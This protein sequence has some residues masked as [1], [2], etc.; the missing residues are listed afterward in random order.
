M[1]T[2]MM[3]CSF[4]DSW[5]IGFKEP[6]IWNDIKD[7]TKHRNN[8]FKLIDKR[9]D[10]FLKM[11]QLTLR[12]RAFALNRIRLLFSLEKRKSQNIKEFFA[13]SLNRQSTWPVVEKQQTNQN[14]LRWT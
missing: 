4:L 1:N 10:V 7:I 12:S 2:Y 9:F 13:F 8:V 11:A 6:T 5:S 14:L 3:Y